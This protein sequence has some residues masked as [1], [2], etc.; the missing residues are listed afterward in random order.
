MNTNQPQIAWSIL[1]DCTI[2]A[3]FGILRVRGIDIKTVEPEA[4]SDC[5][6]AELTARRKDK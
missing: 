1:A 2:L 5:L 3:A 6:K 4:L